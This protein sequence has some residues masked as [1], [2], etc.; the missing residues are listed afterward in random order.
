MS[1]PLHSTVS[2]KLIILATLLAVV[3]V[4]A[5]SWS[6]TKVPALRRRIMGFAGSSSRVRRSASRIAIWGQA[7]R[8][9]SVATCAVAC[10][11]AFILGQA[12]PALAATWSIQSTPTPA[13][14]AGTALTGVSCTTLTACIAVGDYINGSGDELTLAEQWNGTSWSILPTPTT[15]AGSALAGVS[16]TAASVCTAVGY[17]IDASG[18]KMTLVERWN[19][20]AWS[21]LPS[22]DPT[23]GGVLSSVW[24]RAS[25]CTA[26]GNSG[27]N[28]PLAERWNGTAWVI[29]PTPTPTGGGALDGLSCTSPSACTAV[30]QSQGA[31]LAE[32]WNGTA[33][34]IQTTPTPN[35]GDVFVRSSMLSGVSCASATGCTAVGWWNGIHCNNGQP[36]CN[37]LRSPYC[38]VKNGT[39]VEAWDSASWAIQSS[40]FSSGG[41]SLLGVSCVSATTCTAN[42]AYA[43]PAYGSPLAE[44][45]NGSTWTYQLPPPPSSSGIVLGESLLGVSCTAATACTA[46]GETTTAVSGSS[47]P[48]AFVERYS[49]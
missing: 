47:V 33:W 10:A 23:G 12:A 32:R 2:L 20:T 44:Q 35:P 38:T 37:C 14:A 42:G 21:N 34:S 16:C 1:K 40:P 6:A 11:A 45:W 48:T 19:G 22:A 5:C 25:G 30:G 31:P 9:M 24:C 17:Y 36:T 49:G 27:Q 15:A 8:W 39:L 41:G 29:Q 43:V 28:A 26:V 7:F 13:G 46:V 18:V 3:A 4:V